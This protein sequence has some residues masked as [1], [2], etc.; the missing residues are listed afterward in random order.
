MAVYGKLLRIF[1]NNSSINLLHW[2]SGMKNTP[3]VDRHAALGA[4]MVDFSGWQMPI[5]YSE[6]IVAEHLATRKGAGLFD[7]SHMGRFRVTGGGAGAFLN[8]VLTNDCSKLAVGQAQYT[9]LANEAG[10]AIDDAFLYY[11]A[12]GK[13]LLV[14]N[15]SNKDKDW[16]HLQSHLGGFEDVQLEDVSD[17]VAML[18]LQ[19]PE[20]EKILHLLVTDGVL[21]EKKRNALGALKL[22]GCDVCVARTG[23]TGE[24]VCFELFIPL[25][26][27]G[28]IWDKLV[29]AG[30]KPVGL[31]ARDTL[32][33]EAGLPLYGHEL[34]LDADGQDIPVCTISQG[35]FA[36]NLDDAQRDFI[37]KE[38]I[39][40]QIQARDAYKNGDFSDCSVLGKIVRQ[41]QL[42]DKG[43]ARDGAVVYHGDRMVGRVSSGTMVPYWCC[44]QEGDTVVLQDEHAQRAVAM[45]LMDPT[46]KIGETV[47]VDVRGRKLCA[48]V[49]LK[50]LE[51][52]KGDTTYA[53]L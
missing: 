14:V 27:A 46:I 20:S 19:G 39:E 3:F 4:K 18:A 25:E 50:N 13:Y 48:K 24:P 11:P 17:S 38:A 41:I 23:Y 10:G 34:G 47:Q 30:A 1:I 2:I 42:V 16:G 51:N 33:L 49:V 6:G 35:R 21:P 22:A 9:I 12:E 7:V 52:R 36:I 31:G 37:G 40:R 8:H 29:D 32:R 44:G 15:A 45:C 5:Q 53:V 26:S 43:I 28:T